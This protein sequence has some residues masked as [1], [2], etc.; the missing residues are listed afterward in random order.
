MPN[1]KGLWYETAEVKEERL[2]NR[3]VARRELAR[4]VHIIGLSPRQRQVLDGYL[5]YESQTQ[6]AQNL[7]I[8]R[9]AVKAHWH[10][11]KIKLKKA[12]S[13]PAPYSLLGQETTK[14]GE[15]R[16]ELSLSLG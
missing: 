13:L 16:R 12:G 5:H 4:L 14:K 10:R 8:K 9:N 3:S 2:A 15:R 6:I 7:D 11:V 1:E